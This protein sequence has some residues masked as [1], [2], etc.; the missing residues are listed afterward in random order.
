MDK[1]KILVL[2]NADYLLST[3]E[4][5]LKRDGYEVT[6]VSKD[7]E[8]IEL[9]EKEDYDLLLFDIPHAPFDS[10]MFFM[11]SA[12][13]DL[14]IIHKRHPKLPIIALS[15]EPNIYRAD[16]EFRELGVVKGIE[17]PFEAKILSESVKEA[18]KKKG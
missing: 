8:A 13:D 18:L 12:L 14:E 5:L 2:D 11:K 16:I 7:K 3:Y 15:T 4:L 6:F 10:E 9:L 17:K 1:G